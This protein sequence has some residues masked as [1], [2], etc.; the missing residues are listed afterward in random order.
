MRV[1][2]IIYGIVSFGYISL[3]QVMS[4]VY[5][6]NEIQGDT[7]P[8]CKTDS[9]QIMGNASRT[10]LVCVPLTVSYFFL[11]EQFLIFD[12]RVYNELTVRIH[13]HM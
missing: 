6:H 8:I 9:L 12:V 7:P 4:V 5:V 11:S 13:L 2:L 1:S 3:C 10:N